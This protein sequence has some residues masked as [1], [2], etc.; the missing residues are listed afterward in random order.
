EDGIRDD[1]VTG[2]QTCALPISERNLRPVTYQTMQSVATSHEH[3]YGNFFNSNL[4]TIS[5]A[6]PITRLPQIKDTKLSALRLAPSVDVH[7]IPRADPLQVA[8]T[9]LVNKSSSSANRGGLWVSGDR[10]EGLER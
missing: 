3:S 5:A 10:R 8:F 4:S 2:V 1:L 9:I 6:R 7:T